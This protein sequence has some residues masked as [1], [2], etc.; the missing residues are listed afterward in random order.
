LSLVKGAA[1]KSTQTMPQQAFS[2]TKAKEIYKSY[3]SVIQ[4]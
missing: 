1:K 2:A 3:R 4:P